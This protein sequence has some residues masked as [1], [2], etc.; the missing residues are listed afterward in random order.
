[1][2]SKN[3]IKKCMTR[4]TL[5]ISFKNFKYQ[6]CFRCTHLKGNNSNMGRTCVSSKRYF[7]L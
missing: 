3:N 1:M 2:F 7:P 6:L 5:F 4:N